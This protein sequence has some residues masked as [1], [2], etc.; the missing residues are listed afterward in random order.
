LA[1]AEVRRAAALW[2][3]VGARSDRGLCPLGQTAV[4]RQPISARHAAREIVVV[5]R[6]KPLMDGAGI[7]LERMRLNDSGAQELELRRQR[8]G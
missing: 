4:I 2:F 3:S 1:V 5:E 6:F 7:A 8:I